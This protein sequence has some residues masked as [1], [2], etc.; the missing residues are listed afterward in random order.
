MSAPGNAVDRTVDSELSS[1]AALRDQTDR[2]LLLLVEA[3][4]TLLAS[5]QHVDVVHTVMSLAQRFVSADAYALWRQTDSTTWKA[6]H[7]L[8]LSDQYSR[9][10]SVPTIEISR[11]P[12]VPHAFSDFANEP[13]LA[14]RREEYQAEGIQAMLTVPLMLHGRLGGTLVFYYRTPHIFT[15]RETTIAGALGNLA[16]AA[17]GT[18][19]LYERQQD[20]RA[21]AE[22]L[23][24]RAAFL[25]EAG[26]VL[27]SS[28][29]YQATL[30]NV[31]ELLVPF[32]ADWCAVNVVDEARAVRRLALKH[33]DPEKENVALELQ[34]VFPAKNNVAV[35]LALRTR[36]P[37][38]MA[39]VTNSL[40]A[41]HISSAGEL[42]VLQSLDLK[43]LICVPLVARGRTLGA[44][45][46]ATS[47]S[48]RSYTHE[49]VDFAQELT[50]RIA[51]AV[52]NARL[53][54]EV[55]SER[56]LA[57]QT[58][59]TLK[60]TNDA[61]IRANEDLEQFAYSASHDLQEPLRTVAVYSQLLQR[62]LGATVDQEA[63]TFLQYTIAGAKRMEALMKDLLS[64]VQATRGVDEKPRSISAGAVLTQTLS[65]LQAS[66]DESGAIIT[67]G[68]LPA[69]TVEAVHLEQL[70]QNLIGNA[71]KY[72]NQEP[73]RIEIRAW[74][75]GARYVFCVKDNG[76]GIDPKYKKQV[77]G[78]FKRLHSSSA[79]SG[80]GIGLAICQKIVDRYRGRIWV[81]SEP[82]QGS[83]FYF[84]LPAG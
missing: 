45:V 71:I 5:P 75:Q 54:A 1:G 67:F 35:R 26:A 25:A 65:N 81:D 14:I 20:L 16:A 77:F 58:N 48:S 46:L 82:G 13:R 15:E 63:E 47:D 4:T 84:T 6:I 59:Q 64:Y 49:D 19:D 38:F 41:R 53:F 69:V 44:L 60:E 10:L 31:A 61:L 37:V 12:T 76:I 70:F 21:Q 78:I 32:F 22:R 34:R 7:T 74:R 29:E 43:S 79:Y 66:I 8:N 42:A 27:S 23:A 56:E 40:L 83:A 39:E 36:K 73:P 51:L 2:E 80:T 57:Q 72:R 52:D 11:W 55:T 62:H 68:E 18:A 33:R 30:A 50:G 17:I 3:S 24:S 28:L 9:R